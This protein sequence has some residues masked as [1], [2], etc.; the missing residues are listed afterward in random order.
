MK[1]II[2]TP[3]PKDYT[4]YVFTSR[5]GFQASIFSD[6]KKWNFSITTNKY[7]STTSSTFFEKADKFQVFYDL[8][9]ASKKDF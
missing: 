3:V 2:S 8:V 9:V 1:E 5:S 7:I 4:E 6:E